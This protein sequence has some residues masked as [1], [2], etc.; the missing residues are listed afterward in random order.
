[1]TKVL[2]IT[3]WGRSGTTILDN[4]LG[5]VDGFV[6]TGELHYVWKR[7]LRDNRLCGCGQPLRDC[8]TWQ[9]VFEQGFGGLD[10][11]AVA[12]VITR[13][14][15]VHTRGSRS[16]LAAVRSHQVRETYPY[17]DDLRRTYR[18]IEQATG[19]RV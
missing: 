4:L 5:Q 2:Y 11:V 10:K 9:Q 14:G 16:I 13:Q 7:G 6:S 17:A 3:G 12:E 1:M 18:G 8:E 15:A 19:A